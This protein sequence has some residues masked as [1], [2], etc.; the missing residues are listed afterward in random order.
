MTV[1]PNGQYLTNKERT[2]PLKKCQIKRNVK[3]KCI[4]VG[5]CRCKYYCILSQITLG[6]PEGWMVSS[7][8]LKV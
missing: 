6:L 7:I 3:Q 8:N 4:S 5:S 1:A 2:F